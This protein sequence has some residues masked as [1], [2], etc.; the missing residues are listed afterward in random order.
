MPMIVV[1]MFATIA[2]IAATVKPCDVQ[3]MT[4]DLDH[5]FRFLRRSWNL[6]RFYAI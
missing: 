1:A 6:Y 4:I 5:V 3:L 2:G